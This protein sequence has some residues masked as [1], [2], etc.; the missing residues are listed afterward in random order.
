M[1]KFEGTT[2]IVTGGNT[3]IGKEICLK[4]GM[5]KANVVVNYIFNEEAADDVVSHIENLGGKGLIVK[6]DVS[7]FEDSKAIIESAI[8]TFKKVDIF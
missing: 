8:S 2:V 7:N 4:Y 6:G 1:A 5:K 3:G